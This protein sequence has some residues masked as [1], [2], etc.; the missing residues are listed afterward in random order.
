MP[1]L[2]FPLSATSKGWN[3]SHVTRMSDNSAIKTEM[4]GGYMI[5]RPRHTRKPRLTYAIGWDLMLDSDRVIL[6][7]FWDTMKG[8]SNSFFWLDPIDNVNV[9]VR[10]KTDKLTFNYAGMGNTRLWNVTLELESV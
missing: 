9:V 8:T 6:Q 10:F 1:T 5:S 7:N 4:E 2:T 3:S